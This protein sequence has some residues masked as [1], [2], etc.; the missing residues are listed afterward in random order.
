MPFAPCVLAED[1]LTYFETHLS[2]EDFKF[3]TLHVKQKICNEIAPAIVHVD[4]TARPQSIFKED[5][6]FM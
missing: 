3:M 2:V 1:F 4:K 6:N 5:N